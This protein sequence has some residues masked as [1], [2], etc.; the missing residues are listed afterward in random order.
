MI[1]PN[2]RI[3]VDSRLIQPGDTFVATKSDGS[4]FYRGATDRQYSEPYRFDA[5][6]HISDAISRGASLIVYSN[7]NYAPTVESGVQSIFVEDSIQYLVEL[8][9]QVI[10]RTHKRVVGITGSTG[11]STTCELTMRALGAN[12]TY[13]HLSDRPT[14]ISIPVRALNSPHFYEARHFVVEMPMDGLG[15]ITELCQ[16]TPPDVGVIININDSHLQQLGSLDNIVSAKMELVWQVV[17]N[18][19]EIVLNGDDPYLRPQERNLTRR[20]IRTTTFGRGVFNDVR[21]VSSKWDGSGYEHTFGRMGSVKTLKTRFVSSSIAYSL[22]AAISAAICSGVSFG[23]AIENLQGATPLP[24]RMSALK[25]Q[26]GELILDD[27]RLATPQSTLEL[28]KTSLDIP[29]NRKILIQGPVLREYQ[30]G[31]LS[32][33]AFALMQRF[34]VVLLYSDASWIP[35]PNQFANLESE[36][37]LLDWYSRTIQAGDLVVFN[38]SEGAK[39]W[40]IVK[41]FVQPSEVGGV[42]NPEKHD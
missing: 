7:P 37:S 40:E 25:G 20:K 13:K 35:Y 33:E 21:I 8:L 29:M 2:S 6:P 1:I 36:D 31:Q 23:D 15:Q 26:R 18:Q 38:G 32:R 28:L 42:Y 14:P 9:N 22:G 5:H 17:A 41:Q 11:K 4:F 39:M 27:T 10:Q 24:G 34:D 12:Q 16:V 30:H 3:V 19:G